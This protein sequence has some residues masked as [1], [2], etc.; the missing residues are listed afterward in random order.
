M[1]V[2]PDIIRVVLV[3]ILLELMVNAIRV[4]IG[5][6]EGV[7]ALVDKMFSGMLIRESTVSDSTIRCKYVAQECT[8][9][10]RFLC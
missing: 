4:D 10:L 5:S 2:M 9:K 1:V 7:S 8:W 6:V 3:H